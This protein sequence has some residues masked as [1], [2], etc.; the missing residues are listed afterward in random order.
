MDAW[1]TK[2]SMPVDRLILAA[3]SVNG[4]IYTCGG[5]RAGSRD[6]YAELYIYDTGYITGI[7][8]NS[9]KVD[10]FQLHQNYPNPFNPSTHISFDVQR[11]CHVTLKVYD[12]M[13]RRVSTLVNQ[14]M[15]KGH[16]TVQFNGEG[17]SSGIYH[18]RI[19]MGDDS[20]TRTM[21]LSN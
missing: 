17:L 8:T 10:H 5:E 7:E 16:H 12:V 4:K 19:E 13:G 18:Y 3:C 15:E 11:N 6:K 1:T 20:K 2:T 9:L 14:Q 21:S